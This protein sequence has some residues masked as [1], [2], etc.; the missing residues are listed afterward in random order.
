M[1]IKKCKTSFFINWN[2]LP[3]HNPLMSNIIHLS[4]WQIDIK[5][6]SNTSPF[7]VSDQL[8]LSIFKTK[9]LL[10]QL[11]TPWIYISIDHR[12]KKKQVTNISTTKYN[13]QVRRTEE[14]NDRIFLHYFHYHDQYSKILFFRAACH[15]N[16]Y[17]W[18][19]SVFL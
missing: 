8:I 19:L 6:Y 18:Y 12:K 16:Y 1:K 9:I 17:H 15:I 3:Q 4:F 7:F 5:H 14:K 13:I 10:F 2:I 11:L